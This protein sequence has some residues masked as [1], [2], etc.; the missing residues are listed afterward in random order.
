MQVP[1]FKKAFT[2]T[3]PYVDFLF[4]NET[5]AEAFAESEGWKTKNITEIAGKVRHP[6]NWFTMLSAEGG[7]QKLH[8]HC[9]LTLSMV[10]QTVLFSPLYQAARQDAGLLKCDTVFGFLQIASLPKENGARGR[11]VVI[12]QGALPTVVASQGKVSSCV[13]FLSLVF[14]NDFTQ[15]SMLC[16]YGGSSSPARSSVLRCGFHFF[17]PLAQCLAVFAATASLAAQECLASA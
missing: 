10:Q 14:F 2:E 5:E 13:Y 7:C 16:A 8:S 12:T 9:A 17:V 6:C 1:P 4:G 11:T 15:S 3:M